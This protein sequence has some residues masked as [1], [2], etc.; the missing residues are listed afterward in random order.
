M[1]QLAYVDEVLETFRYRSKDLPVEAFQ[2]FTLKE[3]LNHEG[4]VY[5]VFCS[6]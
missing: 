1:P 5:Q 3:L 6:L 4:Y 2:I